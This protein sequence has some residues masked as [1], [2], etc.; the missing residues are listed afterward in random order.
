MKKALL[1]LMMLTTILFASACSGN[2]NNSNNGTA[3]P[4]NTTSGTNKGSSSEG[5]TNDELLSEKYHVH[6]P[7]D[8]KKIH[9]NATCIVP[10]CDELVCSCGETIAYVKPGTEEYITEYGEHNFVNGVCSVCGETE[11]EFEISIL[12]PKECA[13]T[14]YNGDNKNL[15]I[16]D[17][18]YGL[19]VTEI[20]SLTGKLGNRPDGILKSFNSITFG[21]N[22]KRFDC[23]GFDKNGNPVSID[24]IRYNSTIYDFVNIDL[25]SALKGAKKV[26]VDGKDI[27]NL[28]LPND[29]N[30][31]NSAY[32]FSGKYI[33]S[34]TLPDN[35]STMG[36]YTF[37]IENL[38]ASVFNVDSNGCKYL[39]TKT[40]DK[41]MLVSFGDGEGTIELNSNVKMI[42]GS[43]W[44]NCKYDKVIIPENV[45][46]FSDIDREN[47]ILAYQEG[48]ENK[49]VF[50][51]EIEYKGTLSSW[52]NK[53]F[54][55]YK[56][57]SPD[58]RYLTVASACGDIMHIH[59]PLYLAS[60]FT[61]GNELLKG[62]Y[63]LYS[64]MQDVILNIPE[65]V[66]KANS[67]ALEGCR[68]TRIN[69]PKSLKWIG[70]HA[71][72]NL[73]GIPLYNSDRYSTVSYS[74]TMA[75]WLDID[76]ESYLANPFV[77]DEDY[78]SWNNRFYVNNELITNLVIPEGTK[79][80]KEAQFAGIRNIITIS[81]PDSLKYIG[82]FAFSRC[83]NLS[84]ISLEMYGD[85]DKIGLSE[86]FINNLG[87]RTFDIEI[88][89]TVN[90]IGFGAFESYGGKL[91]IYIPK[92][93][94]YVSTWF[95]ISGR[96]T[97]SVECVCPY[98]YT[99]NEN[100]LDIKWCFP[101]WSGGY[102]AEYAAIPMGSFSVV[103]KCVNVINK[104]EIITK[105]FVNYKK[106]E[107]DKLLFLGSH[108]LPTVESK[109][110]INNGEVVDYFNYAY[111]VDGITYNGKKY[112]VCYDDNFYYCLLNMNVY[113]MSI[114]VTK[115]VEEFDFDFVK[116]N[117]WFHNMLADNR[118]CRIYYEGS[119]EEWNYICRNTDIKPKYYNCTLEDR[120]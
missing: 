99:D 100:Y 85:K 48:Y 111:L 77:N 87:N 80:I 81:F 38:N 61:C 114:Y 8:T 22:V 91:N 59:N 110:V 14:Y 12:N 52:L 46:Y 82:D 117:P 116:I 44:L 63:P 76:F 3:N 66:E 95:Y 109:N 112:K 35:L 118:N 20:Y 9:H 57:V 6:L 42:Y 119:E 5:K 49:E 72:G 15:V 13:I 106:T 25:N 107:D 113:S 120:Q 33:E 79:E 55:R 2:G 105:D 84:A 98:I 65:G 89:K 97:A 40:N 27:K 73:T 50:D 64:D 103:D 75:D 101:R 58:A 45:E 4:Q 62:T 16:P 26:I 28:V 53:N 88:P 102:P 54:L 37:D 41:Y 19:K 1:F 23:I 32:T 115:N 90:Y 34:I 70:T 83:E 36:Y 10:E 21:K 96:T 51:G 43:A 39:G 104:D 71:I 68:F 56:N 94:E 7:D 69:I 93:V 24:E 17:E 67:Y 92:E 29:I 47:V 74:G 108:F 11:S 78:A 60:K 31:T 30:L 86:E 18:I